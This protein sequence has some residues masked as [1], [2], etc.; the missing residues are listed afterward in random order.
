MFGF[1]D[2]TDAGVSAAKKSRMARVAGFIC[3]LSHAFRQ[4]VRDLVARSEGAVSMTG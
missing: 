2:K 1:A 4:N 3:A